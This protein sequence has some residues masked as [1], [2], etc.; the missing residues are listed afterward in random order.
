MQRLI[1]GT[2]PSGASAG[3]GEGLWEVFLDAD[4]GTLSGARQLVETPSPSFVAL[5][6]DGKTLFA[7]AELDEG[8]VTSFTLTD[9]ALEERESRSTAGVHPCHVVARENEV[10]VANYT[11]GTFTTLG[12]D[13]DAAFTGE[14]RSFGHVGSGPD[15]SRQEGPHAHFCLPAP[16]G[17]GAWV[18]DLGTDELRQY[19]TSSGAQAAASATA[20]PAAAL[21][22]FGLVAAGT[23]AT[24][25][26]GSGPR[27][28]AVHPG[29]T[30]YVVGE[31]DSRVH[32]LRPTLSGTGGGATGGGAWEAYAS[33]PACTTPD[34]GTG[35]YPSHISLSADGTRLYV[36]VRGPDVLSTFAI[37]PDGGAITHLADT[38]IGGVW[39]RHFAVVPGT[40]HLG[41]E[42]ASAADLVV[43][44]NQNS[45]TLAVLRMDPVSGAGTLVDQLEL[46]APACVLPV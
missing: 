33:V 42:V 30:V 17:D 22:P 15:A 26:A 32:L 29:G 20:D 12:L 41:G 35:L 40:M 28:A 24:L 2:Y 14:V 11:S 38:P 44:A 6:P 3:S 25:P 34:P 45:S 39:P 19:T 36:A 10:W 43:V 13:D 9:D 18:V 4:A 46:A 5:H 1:I 7:V 31:L 8:A 16:A 23:A 27:H 21:S 37:T